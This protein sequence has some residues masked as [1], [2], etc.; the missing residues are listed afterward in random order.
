MQW[1]RMLLDI[2]AR[3]VRALL[4]TVLSVQKSGNK[5][6]H[7]VA[8]SMGIFVLKSELVPGI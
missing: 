4:K 7:F 8:L 5:K 3:D 1:C 2:E 6:P